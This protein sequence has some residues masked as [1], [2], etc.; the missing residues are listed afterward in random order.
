MVSML[1][2]LLDAWFGGMCLH[3]SSYCPILAGTLA[4][5]VQAVVWGTWG[6]ELPTT[7]QGRVH[8]TINACFHP[9]ALCCFVLVESRPQICLIPATISPLHIPMIHIPILSQL[10]VTS[11]FSV[12]FRICLLR[13]RLSLRGGWGRVTSPG[14]PVG[15]WGWGAPV[16]SCPLP[17]LHP[18]RSWCGVLV[19]VACPGDCT[20]QRAATRLGGWG[21]VMR[22]WGWLA[23]G[24][25]LMNHPNGVGSSSCLLS[26]HEC[27]G[28]CA[29]VQ[30]V[31]CHFTSW[32]GTTSQQGFQWP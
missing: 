1:H 23:Q 14:H 29:S 18:L 19:L 16:L 24:A 20:G 11:C 4:V 32:G 17:I 12:V 21:Y 6:G 30:Q 27:G 22:C 5:C 7:A 10:W 15:G 8:N 3:A 31:P 26:V 9:L 13:C 28:S 2:V 25:T